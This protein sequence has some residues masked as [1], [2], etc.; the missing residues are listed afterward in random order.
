MTTGPKIVLQGA[1]VGPQGPSGPSGPTGPTGSHGFGQPGPTG[2]PGNGQP[3][4]DGS[5]GPTGPQ[6]PAGGATGP[7]GAAST[8]PGPTGPTGSAGAQGATGPTGPSG[9]QGI[10]GPTGVGATGPTG[11]DSTIVGPTGPTGVAAGPPGP[12]GAPGPSGGATGSPGPQGP[13]GATGATGAVSTVP[14]PTGAQGTVGFAGLSGLPGATG[15]TGPVGATGAR[16][17][18]GFD[19]LPGAAGPT[20]AASTIAGPTGVPGP[21]GP[22]GIT[23]AA[24]T[25]VGPTGPTGVAAGPTGPPGP[26]GGATG[27][28]GPTGP[29]GA[30]GA[31]G[32]AGPTGAK[33]STGSTGSAG[34]T[35]F[36]GLPGVQ[37]PTGASAGA[38]FGDPVTIAHGGTNQTTAQAA[39]GP[40]G[41]NIDQIVT[42]ADADHSCA[43]TDRMILYTALTASRIVALPAATSVNAG[44]SIVIQDG[45]GN[46][47]L[48][49]QIVLEW[50]ITDTVVGRTSVTTPGGRITA[51]SDGVAAWYADS[52]ALPPVGVEFQGAG[53]AVRSA[54]ISI[55][56][57]GRVTHLD[58]VPI[59]LFASGGDV[60]G[61][62]N[63]PLDLVDF[64]VGPITNY[65]GS[66]PSPYTLNISLD[67]AGRVSNIAYVPIA[68]DG[69]HVTS[70]LRFHTSQSDHVIEVTGG[71]W[72]WLD[73]ASAIVRSFS[74]GAQDDGLTWQ[75]PEALEG[76]VYS[77]VW[78]TV[79]NPNGGIATI[80]TSPPDM[81]SWSALTEV[82]LFNPDNDIPAVITKT[83]L[84]I[85]DGTQ[86]LRHRMATKHPDSGGFYS[87]ICS[88]DLVRT[89]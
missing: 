67:H 24:S 27:S 34:P 5:P 41:L 36:D 28:Q 45:T 42:V 65:P 62:P 61:D 51:Y 2:P 46:A 9:P 47:S 4:A 6:G 82:D 81:S 30:A 73:T 43:A 37:G 15:S 64:G 23:G 57:D 38:V 17:P 85:P 70:G 59:T 26:T 52:S 68:I 55:D 56:A 8:I 71:A 18:T 77:L 84:A 86:F 22:T 80:E 25:V 20:G 72:T 63:G 74:S 83:E 7:T 87:V 54:R 14:G 58:D 44:Q 32:A 49:V 75:I 60:I 39:R 50:P 3:G 33:G 88:L 12:T 48:A 16:G 89:A 1:I 76:G 29:T 69:A 40:T 10:A 19:G 11:A 79:T 53:T 78:H 13:T 31:A 35:G 21:T 66:N